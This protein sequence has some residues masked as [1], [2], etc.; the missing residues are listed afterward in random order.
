MYSASRGP[1]LL[2]LSDGSVFR[3]RRLG[4]ETGSVGL[5]VFNTSMTGYEEMLTDPSYG[6]QILVPTYPLIG[7]YGIN[8]KDA[9]SKQIQVKGFVVRDDCD[10]PSHP[11]SEMTIH[12][13]LE[14]N[15]IPG[16]SGVDTRAITRR[17]RSTGV[18]MGAI[19]QGE[20][21]VAA[22]AAL[23]AAQW[24]GDQNWVDEVATEQEFDW[25]GDGTE[26]TRQAE[27]LIIRSQRASTVTDEN[28]GER[29]LRIAVIDFGVKWNILRNMRARNCQ[30][31]VFPCYVQASEV[32]AFKPDGIVLSPG[33]GDPAVLHGPVETIRELSDL[34][35][36]GTHSIP[37]LGICLGH[38]LVARA[39][40]ADT[41]MLHFG[42]RGGNQPVQDLR[43]G[44]VR[45]TAQNHGY[46]VDPDK[47]P[48]RPGVSVTHINLNDNTVAGLA[49]EPHGIMTI[50]FHSEASP[51][52]HDSE[53]IFDQFV[54]SIR[55][56]SNRR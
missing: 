39:L 56:R 29:P 30:V 26:G 16:V 10:A 28:D 52:P 22:T 9:E 49:D 24:Y 27:E 25:H 14:M 21:H 38:Q 40:G 44:R 23:E 6:G 54:A 51:G 5:V 11:H 20:D 53:M 43:S 45:V 47:L 36:D 35:G 1:S 2:A 46:A 37:T 4:A 18:M 13:Y 12:E 48:D 32:K 33:P 17:I 55:Q 3:G 31:K 7:N 19:M 41:F 8:L 34:G 15:G 42:H 50:Q